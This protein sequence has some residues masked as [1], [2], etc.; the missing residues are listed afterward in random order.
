MEFAG[1]LKTLGNVAAATDQVARGAE[2]EVDF[3][4]ESR[5]VTASSTC[6][7]GP[8]AGGFEGGCKGFGYPGG[9]IWLVE[10]GPVLADEIGGCVTVHVRVDGVEVEEPVVFEDG[11]AFPGSLEGGDYPGGIAC[12]ILYLLFQLSLETMKFSSAMGSRKNR[13]EGFSEDALNLFVVSGV[14]RWTGAADD[15]QFGGSGFGV[16]DRTMKED[17]RGDGELRGRD[18]GLGDKIGYLAERLTVGQ[19]GG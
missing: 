5:S 6:L 3:D 13:S 15:P 14:R 19:F 2:G 10:G 9:F 8:E 11:N 1:G 17:D 16:A 12:A 4:V 7:T 18:L